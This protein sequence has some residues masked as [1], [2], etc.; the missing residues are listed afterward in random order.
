MMPAMP[1][2]I[3]QFPMLR[4]ALSGSFFPNHRLTKVQQPSPIITAI[5]NATTVR[6]KTTVF[7]A[8]P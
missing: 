3:M 6:G 5:A 1:V 7:A 2:S 8:L 4:A